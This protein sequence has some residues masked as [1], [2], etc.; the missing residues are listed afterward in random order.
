M[1]VEQLYLPRLSNWNDWCCFV[2]TDF[3]AK[4]RGQRKGNLS[5]MALW[6]AELQLWNWV[7]S[8]SF[9]E[10]VIRGV[11]FNLLCLDPSYFHQ[12]ILEKYNFVNLEA[13]LQR[14]LSITGHWWY[15]TNPI[16]NV[17]FGLRRGLTRGWR[18][19]KNSPNITFKDLSDPLLGAQHEQLSSIVGWTTA[20]TGSSG[21]AH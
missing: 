9:W 1:H 15:W 4:T 3:T 10:M 19:E 7:F 12:L 2:S 14:L 11:L 8:V 5:K 21:R 6:I 20:E 13:S 18:A 17:S 16:E